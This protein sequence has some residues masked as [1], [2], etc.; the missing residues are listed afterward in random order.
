MIMFFK[1]F[2]NCIDFGNIIVYNTAVPMGTENI[3]KKGYLL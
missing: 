2:V 1:H 3:N